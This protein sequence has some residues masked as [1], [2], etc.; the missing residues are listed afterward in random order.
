MSRRGAGVRDPSPTARM[1]VGMTEDER[2]AEVTRA[3]EQAGFTVTTDRHYL[4]AFSHMILWDGT[5][6]EAWISRTANGWRVSD[7][8][9]AYFMA[10]STC[11]PA[12]TEQW[13]ALAWGYNLTCDRGYWRDVEDGPDLTTRL[14]GVVRDVV[15]FQ[16]AVHGYALAMRDVRGFT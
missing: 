7:L 5:G 13:E 12:E 3:L 11:M 10:V 6:V 1:M 8:G 16:I 2:R 9:Q 14:V 15:A 4:R